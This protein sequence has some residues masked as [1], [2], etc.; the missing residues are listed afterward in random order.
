MWSPPAKEAEFRE[1]NRCLPWVKAL[2]L[3]HQLIAET[4]IGKSPFVIAK[5]ELLKSTDPARAKA[6][7]GE[8][9]KIFANDPLT[10]QDA[11]R[12]II[13]NEDAADKALALRIMEQAIQR[14]ATGDPLI[15][16]HH[17]I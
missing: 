12:T 7:G 11:A 14:C 9:M 2:R 17:V 5:Y 3:A 1:T 16:A 4:I 6:Y 13:N 10:L 8:I 15:P